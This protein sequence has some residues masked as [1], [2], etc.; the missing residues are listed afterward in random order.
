MVSSFITTSQSD[1]AEH[2]S[3]QPFQ[4]LCRFVTK[5]FS[6]CHCFAITS[7]KVPLALYFCGGHYLEC[8]IY[9]QQSGSVEKNEMYEARCSE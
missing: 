7:S 8:S 3:A 1:A 6:T 9:Q 5:P 2:P 4:E